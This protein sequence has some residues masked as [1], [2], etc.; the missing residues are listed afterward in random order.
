VNPSSVAWW[1]I[2]LSG[3]RIF[4]RRAKGTDIGYQRLGIIRDAL[5]ATVIEADKAR[6]DD[7]ERHGK[8]RQEWIFLKW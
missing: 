5:F 6:D 8:F 4:Q 1:Q 3:Q 7:N 2:D